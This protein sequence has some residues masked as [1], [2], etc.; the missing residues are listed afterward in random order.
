MNSCTLFSCRP[1]R[2]IFALQDSLRALEA[3]TATVENSLEQAHPLSKIILDINQRFG[4]AFNVEDKVILNSLSQRLMQ[5]ETLEGSIKN[6]NRHA[7]KIKFDVLFNDELVTMLN[8]HF[9]LYKKLDENPEL[10][11]YVNDRI[12]DF[13]HRKVEEK[14]R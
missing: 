1:E 8:S 9:D 4:T 12:F 7:S 10:K 13:V 2:S 3:S 5:N 6:N 14:V 11:S